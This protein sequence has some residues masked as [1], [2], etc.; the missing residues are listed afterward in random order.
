MK[1]KTTRPPL[2][3]VIIPARNAEATISATLDSVLSQ[4][5]DG[6]LEAI[7]ADGSDT[8]ALSALVRAQYP[9]V[10][11]IPN[12]GRIVSTGLNAG[13][14]AAKG[15]IVFRCDAHSVLPAGYVRRALETLER[16]GAAHVGGRQQPVGD[17]FFE[18]AVAMAMTMR[19]GTGGTRSKV[20]G[21][22]GPTDTVFGG[23]FQR[24]ALEAVG[25]FD[26]SL[27]R[28]QDYELN[29]RL[30][31]RGK[32]IWLDPEL[33]AFYKPRSSLAGLAMQYFEYAWWKRVVL[34]RFPS[35][36]K[37]RQLAVPLFMLMLAASAVLALVGAPMP[38]P[39]AVPLAYVGTLVVGSLV[40]GVRRREW[41]ALLLPVVLATM[42][43]SW[44][45]GFFFPVRPKV[46]TPASDPTG[47]RRAEGVKNP[48]PQ[49]KCI[50]ASTKGN[51]RAAGSP[52]R[53]PTTKDPATS[54]SK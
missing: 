34:M 47:G 29:W 14:K 17:T 48:A 50:V 7:V 9:S 8:P 1:R 33:A 25:G 38:V 24:Q 51:A 18:R 23:A 42:H 28:N 40:A 26:P 20:G 13:L 12:P 3:S 52:R 36:A 4:D 10:R 49:L 19:L 2:V 6:P 44:G 37:A 21:P 22:E 32:V 35:S 43:F 16:T 45:A 31:R 11:L 15:E 41:A 46:P 27:G 53:K 54:A 39:V 30:R 5:Y